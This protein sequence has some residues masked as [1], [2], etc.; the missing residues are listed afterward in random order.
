MLEEHT[1][2]FFQIAE[3]WWHAGGVFA[4]IRQ[5]VILKQK[6][7]IGVPLQISIFA[8]TLSTLEAEHLLHYVIY[9]R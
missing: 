6:V 2:S 9:R 8:S 3:A 1:A 4:R 5:K 7:T